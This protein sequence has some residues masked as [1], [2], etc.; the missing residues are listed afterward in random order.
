MG[1]AARAT[2]AVASG[3]VQSD[4]VGNDIG[5]LHSSRG[6]KDRAGV[7]THHGLYTDGPV[8]RNGMLHLHDSLG[9]GVEIDWSFV[10]KHRA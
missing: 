2:R 9:F 4:D 7:V 6:G 3:M 8:V 1:K 5:G 10:Q